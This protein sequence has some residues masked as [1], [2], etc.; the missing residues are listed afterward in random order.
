MFCLLI[1]I[2][3]FVVGTQRMLVFEKKRRELENAEIDAQV[4]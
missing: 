2:V 1:I 4:R 3:S